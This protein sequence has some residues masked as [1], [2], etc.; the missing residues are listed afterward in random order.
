MNILNLTNNLNS[1]NIVSG[2]YSCPGTT[3]SMSTERP[4]AIFAIFKNININK[5][6]R[7]VNRPV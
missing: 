5:F 3:I 7:F 1:L 4:V 6:K 2:T